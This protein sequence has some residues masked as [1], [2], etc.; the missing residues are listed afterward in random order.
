MNKLDKLRQR[1]IDEEA[2]Q[3]DE[4]RIERDSL[5]PI[6]LYHTEMTSRGG[7]RVIGELQNK[8]IFD[9]HMEKYHSITNPPEERTGGIEF[10]LTIDMYLVSMG[11]GW[12]Q[13]QLRLPYNTPTKITMTEWELLKNNVYPERLFVKEANRWP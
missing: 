9:A 13:D 6:Y 7:I 12:I 2:R 8:N 3:R 11:G 5:K 4:Q 10:I 1:V